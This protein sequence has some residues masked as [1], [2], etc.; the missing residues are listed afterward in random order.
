VAVAD[1]SLERAKGVAA[2]VRALGAPAAALACDVSDWNSVL[3]MKAAAEAALGPPSLIFANAGVTSFEPLDRMTPGEVDW[4]VQTNLMGVMHCVEAFL[5]DRLA[6]GEGHFVAT[7][8]AGALTPSM[9][10]NQIP[11][12]ATKMAL[13][14]LM[15]NLE[16]DYGPRGVHGTVLLPGGV[17]S[18]IL[19]GPTVR[20][21]RF[22]GPGAP[23]ALATD[24]PAVPIAFRSPDEVARMTLLAVRANRP[25]VVTDET[26]R[27]KFQRLYVDHVMRAFDDL[28]AFIAEGEDR[29]ET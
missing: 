3:A 16:A 2:E 1:I 21:E 20:P 6:A 9:V 10:P 7:S 25:V 5:A 14:G 11:Y 12:G 22:G 18:R 13:V 29:E 24:R 26:R 27:E 15:L 4:I 8:S 17:P 23:I 19:E 28:E